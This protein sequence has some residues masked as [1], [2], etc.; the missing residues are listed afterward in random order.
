[1]LPID[2][3]FTG[4]ILLDCIIV[5]SKFQECAFHMLGVRQFFVSE[6]KVLSHNFFLF[7]NFL[8]VSWLRCVPDNMPQHVT[9]VRGGTHALT[10]AQEAICLFVELKTAKIIS[11]CPAPLMPSPNRA[12]N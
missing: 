8:E 11:L 4:N 2:L 3:I 10:S 7:G 5:H 12:T 1:M 9:L 6:K